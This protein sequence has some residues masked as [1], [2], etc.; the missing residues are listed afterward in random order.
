MDDDDDDDDDEEEEEDDEEDEE[1]DD[2]A[3]EAMSAMIE[4][5]LAEDVDV[6]TDGDI[7]YQKVGT[8]AVA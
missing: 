6:P 2:E 5:S 4:A 8:E 3:E 7:K 1:F